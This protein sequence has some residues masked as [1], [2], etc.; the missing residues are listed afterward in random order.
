MCRQSHPGP[1]VCRLHS[2]GGGRLPPHR[3][4]HQGGT[5]RVDVSPGN[6]EAHNRRGDAL[7]RNQSSVSG[8]RHP[9][10][11]AG[12]NHALKS[13]GFRMTQDRLANTCCRPARYR[14]Q[15]HRVIYSGKGFNSSVETEKASG[16]ER[17]CSCRTLSRGTA[18]GQA[19][20]PFLEDQG[21]KCTHGKEGEAR[22]QPWP[23]GSTGQGN[24]GQRGASRRCGR[25]Q[26]GI[27][28]GLGPLSRVA[29]GGRDPCRPRNGGGRAYQTHSSGWVGAMECGGWPWGPHALSPANP[30]EDEGRCPGFYWN[31]QSG[32][33][34]PW[35]HPS[36]RSCHCGPNRGRSRG[37]DK[38]PQ[39]VLAAGMFRV[40]S[41]GSRGWGGV[42]GEGGCVCVQDTEVRARGPHKTQD[43]PRV[44]RA[45]HEL[46]ERRGAAVT[47]GGPR[48]RPPDSRK[49]L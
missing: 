43:V 35:S 8:G 46:W 25:G 4:L 19:P 28:A 49:Q 16:S 3:R 7:R 31:T 24:R 18:Q 44:S 13:L 12:D 26:G 11:P 27:S 45:G 29:L 22:P 33:A 48:G 6:G 39:E 34:L 30:S 23:H 47:H 10:L 15:V 41:Q 32:T 21:G 9:R 20:S 2:P 17:R 40:L 38:G 36:Q 42:T 37:E 14:C 1:G 5:H